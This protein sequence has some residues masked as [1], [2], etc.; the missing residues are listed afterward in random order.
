VEDTFIACRAYP[1]TLL[2]WVG[3]VDKLERDGSGRIFVMTNA[4]T[5]S[6]AEKLFANIGR[7]KIGS[8][9]LSST[10]R[11]AKARHTQERGMN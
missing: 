5:L 4:T 7:G 9:L 10:G 8:N 3:V 11:N 6:T 1:L 2:C